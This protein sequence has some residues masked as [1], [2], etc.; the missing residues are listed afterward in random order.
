MNMTYREKGIDSSSP[1]QSAVPW[2]GLAG[3]TILAT[4]LRVIGINKGLWWD[5]IYF[6]LVSVRHPL[7]EIITL[8]P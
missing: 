6:L 7:A 3:L 2:I 1:L 4:W 8:F 5:E